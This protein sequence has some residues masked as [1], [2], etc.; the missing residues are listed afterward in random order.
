MLHERL[1]GWGVALG[2]IITADR[3]PVA[4]APARLDAV[5]N[6]SGASS[7]K[8]IHRITSD[9]AHIGVAGAAIFVASGRKALVCVKKAL[10]VQWVIPSH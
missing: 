10:G 4:G 6:S 8:D 3:D 5:C 1:V 7:H 9:Q 2:W